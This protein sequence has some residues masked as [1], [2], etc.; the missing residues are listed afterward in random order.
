MH[1]NA[2]R[3]NIAGFLRGHHFGITSDGLSTQI[4]MDCETNAR[5]RR[6]IRF[7]C[8]QLKMKANLRIREAQDKVRYGEA[9][10]E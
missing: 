4:L 1:I 2:L 3:P 6:K 7:R 10:I 9:E 5:L 8:I